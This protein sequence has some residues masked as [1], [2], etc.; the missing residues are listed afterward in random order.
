MTRAWT[1]L[2]IISAAAF[3]LGCQN[4][5]LDENKQLRNQNLELQDS[6]KQKDTDLA[7]RPQASDLAA[8]QGQL[9]DKD[10][11]LADMQAQMNKPVA[12]EIAPAE[13]GFAGITVTRDTK[14]GTI[15]VN[16]PGDV[17]FA[18]GDSAIK[19]G[20][21]ATLG[22]I[23]SVIKKQFASKKLFVDGFTDT[24]PIT[25]TKDKWKD[26]LDLS[27]ARARSVAAAL[28]EDG[29][30]KSQIGVR[31]FGDTAPRGSKAQSRR[32]E[33]VVVTK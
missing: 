24:D 18:S 31:A 1:A 9:A 29:I 6:L 26:N 25:R 17:L 28:T 14:A 33:I 5:V 32:V 27:A 23:A 10:K 19:P 20:A 3:N 8:L 11:Q 4:K 21:K 13:G 22:K 16:V 15:T 30:A 7:G 12:G 2:L